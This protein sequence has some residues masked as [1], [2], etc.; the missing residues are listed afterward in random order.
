V[1][2]PR[3]APARTPI[4]FRSMFEPL[5]RRIL[6]RTRRAR[7]IWRGI[8]LLLV[9]RLT[10]R[11]RLRRDWQFVERRSGWD[12][13]ESRSW[14][15]C[16][17]AIGKRFGTLVALGRPCSQV[18][19]QPSTPYYLVQGPGAHTAFS[20]FLEFSCRRPLG[21]WCPAGLCARSRFIIRRRRDQRIH[22]PRFP[23]RRE[24]AAKAPPGYET[25]SKIRSPGRTR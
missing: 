22:S 7:R 9:L 24:T 21:A 13:A 18:H 15:S 16:S 5:K 10:G 14:C 8:R 23:E 1:R 12:S 2:A 6:V 3:S 4:N 11:L 19:L 20:G 17:G 25:A